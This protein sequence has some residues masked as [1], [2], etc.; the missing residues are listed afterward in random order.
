[1]MGRYPLFYQ[2]LSGSMPIST[3]SSCGSLAHMMK[4]LL[5]VGAQSCEVKIG[6]G[7]VARPEICEPASNL[8]AAYSKSVQ[9]RSE[10][11][12][13]VLGILV[14]IKIQIRGF[15]LHDGP[16]GLSEQAGG[17]ENTKLMNIAGA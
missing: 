8:L 12:K 10:L 9:G 2:R 13:T 17:F 15:C 11:V 1:M 16:K 7:G 6:T 5:C 4:V 3:P 14:I